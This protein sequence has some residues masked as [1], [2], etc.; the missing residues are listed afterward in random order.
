MSWAFWSWNPN[1]GDTGDSGR[2]PANHQHKQGGLSDADH[3]GGAE[4]SWPRSP[5]PLVL[6]T[7]TVT[8]QYAT[9][10]GTATAGSDY[11]AGSGTLSF[12]PGQTTKT[13]AVAIKSDSLTEHRELPRHAVQ[14]DGCQPHRCD[15]NGHHQRPR[16]RH[17]QH[18]VAAPAP[19]HPPTRHPA[20]P[21][22]RR[23]RR[24]RTRWTIPITR[25]LPDPGRHQPVHRPGDAGYLQWQRSHR[26]QRPRGG[27]TAITSEALVAYNDLRRFAG[28][29]PS[30]LEGCRQVGIRP[31]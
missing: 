25:P 31:I 9:M 18:R 19:K 28:L 14:S 2:R 16:G 3:T 24:P 13:I 12:A 23:R 29:T 7:Q 1:S 27:R 21:R 17:R 4:P 15:G 10:N 22:I 20:H 30:N 5:S 26:S 6:S 11:T 8:V